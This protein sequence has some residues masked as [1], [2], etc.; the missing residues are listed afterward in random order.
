MSTV[1]AT[2]AEIHNAAGTP[3]AELAH[4]CLYYMS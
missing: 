3:E 2:G 4:K 1:Q